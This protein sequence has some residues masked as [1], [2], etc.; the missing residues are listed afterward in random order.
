MSVVP[1]LLFCGGLFYGGV[2]GLCGHLLLSTSIMK[3]APRG[4]KEVVR[5]KRRWMV[6]WWLRLMLDAVG[7]FLVYK[8]I[9]LLLGAASGII[10]FHVSVYFMQL[11]RAKTRKPEESDESD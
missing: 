5:Y 1:V 11:K 7:L 3:A 9:P 8:H 4:D 2:I 6:R 10:V